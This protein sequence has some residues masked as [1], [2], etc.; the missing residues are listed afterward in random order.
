MGILTS[1][2]FWA[3]YECNMK[4]LVRLLINA[5]AVLICA[6]FIP[7]VTV[8]GFVSALWVAVAL[9]ILNTFLKPILMLISFPINLITFGL[10]TIIVNTIIILL[11]DYLVPGLTI[12]TFWLAVLFGIVLTI[13]SGILDNL[14]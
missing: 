5:V 8:D 4:L 3:Y 6:Y 9:A 2:L 7:G 10:F 1:F 12:E 13:V 14:D 11:A